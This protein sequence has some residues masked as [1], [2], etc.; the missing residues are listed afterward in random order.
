MIRQGLDKGELEACNGGVELW[1]LEFTQKLMPIRPK[2]NSST[3]HT[4]PFLISAL[5]A[6]GIT[7]ATRATRATCQGIR[8]FSDPIA[9]RSI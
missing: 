4:Y 8:P 7:R 6:S 2:R 3:S 9:H 1:T 5:Q